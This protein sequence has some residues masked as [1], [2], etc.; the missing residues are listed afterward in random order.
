M[1]LV[2]LLAIGSVVVA[3]A[4][5][6]SEVPVD[7]NYSRFESEPLRFEAGQTVTF[8]IR[9]DDPIDHEFILGNQQVQD[10]H[11]LGT[12]AHHDAIP[13][14]VSV[15]AG[16]TVRTTVT[17]DE[18]GKLILGCHLPRHY[19]YGMRAPVTVG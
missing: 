15:P 8:V 17:F 11:E 14:E 1:G 2:G 12:E 6:S 13:T 9:N 7:I 5:S 3:E 10:R 4:R 16:A 19:A 18:P